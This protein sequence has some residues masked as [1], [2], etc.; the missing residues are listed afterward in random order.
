MVGG[1]PAGS[2]VAAFVAAAGWNTLLLERDR[3]PRFH[4]GE[5]LMPETYWTF[6]RLGVLEQLKQSVFVHKVGVQFVAPS[7]SQSQPFYFRQ[8]DAHESSQTWHVDRS[9][10]DMLLF[11][12]AAAKGAICRDGTRVRDVVFPEQG[13]PELRLQDCDGKEIRVTARVV[14]DATGQQALIANRLGLKV[15]NP[16][17]HKAA[18]WGYFRGGAR[19]RAE[20]A[21][22]T[23]ILHTRG[24]RCWFWYIPLVNDRISVGLVGDNDDLLRGRGSAESV[25]QEQQE[26]CPGLMNRLRQAHLEGKLHVAKEF[27]YTTRQHAGDGWVLVGDAYGFIDPIYS[28][29]VFL[30]LKSAELAADSI[31]QALREGDTSAEALGRWTSDYD[32]GVLLFRKMVGAFYTDHFSFAEFIKAHP[33]HQRNLTDLLIGRA[34]REGA[35][36]MFRDLDTA[37]KET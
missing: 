31:N 4:V 25:F 9:D 12:N 6:Q 33:E 7:G 3:M 2:T 28:S 22:L 14:V 30:A 27:S 1:G 15:D 36:R 32:A 35:D 11:K 10:F 29:G 21:E 34:F 26:Q 23:T 18:I 20:G 19:H 37:V 16:K 8:H 13:S 5:S 17:L 24:K